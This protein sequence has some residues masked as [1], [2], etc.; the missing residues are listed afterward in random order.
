MSAKNGSLN[1]IALGN[2]AFPTTRSELA[3]IIDNYK[4]AISDLVVGDAALPSVMAF[5]NPFLAL[6]HDDGSF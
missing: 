1:A 3:T 2:T 6:M 4:A 5:S